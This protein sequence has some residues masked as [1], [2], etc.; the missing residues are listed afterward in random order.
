MNKAFIL[1]LLVAFAAADCGCSGDLCC[2]KWGYCGSGDLYCD[3]AQGCQQNCKGGNNPTPTP[4]T[5][6]TPLPPPTHSKTATQ[7]PPPHP[8]AGRK[9][10]A[11]Y[12][13]QDTIGI[14]DANNLQKNIDWY[15]QDDTYDII[16]AAFVPTYW[17]Q[18]TFKG[19][20]LPELNLANSCENK[21]AAFP[22]T[23]S[24]PDVAA[25]IKKCQAA[26]KKVI[27]SIGGATGYNV[28]TS[29]AAAKEF[30]STMWNMFLGGVNSG[31][32]R[33]F[34]DV[35]VDGIDFDIEGGSKNYY[36]DLAIELK[37]NYFNKATDK[38]YY[39]TSAPQC[40]YPDAYVGDALETGM[41]DYVF[42][43][44]YNNWCGVKNYHN[45][46]AWNWKTWEAL[47]AKHPGMQIFLGVPA[48]TY[49]GG[50]Y[51]PISDLTP[52]FQDVSQSAAYGGAMVWDA[53]VSK[54][55]GFG[56]AIA[57]LVHGN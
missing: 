26:G 44:F 56:E 42:I 35:V 36:S 41:F 38:K 17:G 21:T 10:L 14:H 1:L 6:S 7:N 49:A 25:G 24:C 39:L 51:L 2:S 11:A 57:K 5:S 32:P 4:T 3:P 8:P 34:G 43:Q 33:P 48:D 16:V 37:T 55:N 28:F 23:L 45:Q 18:D 30:A 46:W 9:Q 31:F 50:G 15:C 27:L 54:V 53:T 52:F 12:W 29:A 22:H 20:K 40:E 47:A 13:G 19:I